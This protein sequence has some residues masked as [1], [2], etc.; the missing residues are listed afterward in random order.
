MADIDF[1]PVLYGVCEKIARADIAI[2]EVRAWLAGLNAQFAPGLVQSHFDEATEDF[3]VTVAGEV[4][5]P[6][7]AS[8]LVGEVV[9]H[10]RSVLDHLVVALVK[11]AGKPVT[12]NHAFPVCSQRTSWEGCLKK[13]YL[14]GV[15]PEEVKMIQKAQPYHI[16]NHRDHYLSALQKLDNLDKHQVLVVIVAA[17]SMAEEV[18]LGSID[19]DMSLILQPP[20]GTVR[21]TREKQEIFRAGLRPFRTDINIDVGAKLS[22][23]LGDL[24]EHRDLLVCLDL[25]RSNV[26]GLIAEF[27]PHLVHPKGVS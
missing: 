25:F 2:G 11:D 16:D 19:E 1:P 23:Q 26:L 7:K 6:L 12:R 4:E 13:G 18:R 15:R 17:A 5:V 9:H 22:L 10:L 3:V 8:I 20:V 24:G 14:S 27:I 21:L